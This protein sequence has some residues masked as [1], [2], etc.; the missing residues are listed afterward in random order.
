MLFLSHSCR[1]SKSTKSK[2]NSK[3]TSKK[4]NE[5][6]SKRS[7]TTTTTTTTTTHSP[8]SSG[9]TNN[10][11]KEC[12]LIHLLSQIDT[13][14]QSKSKAVAA[15]QSI[16]QA[17]IIQTVHY[18][19]LWKEGQNATFSTTATSAMSGGS[20]KSDDSNMDLASSSTTTTTTT[21]TSSNN[22]L[23]SFFSNHH[24][25]ATTTKSSSTSTSASTKNKKDNILEA[26][27]NTDAQM[28]ANLIIITTHILNRI[29]IQIQH[30][31][32]LKSA[33]STTTT[34]TTK[35]SKSSSVPQDQEK[36]HT[37]QIKE[38]E[39]RS[40]AVVLS[41]YAS[42][43]IQILL[44]DKS[45]L[46]RAIN[47]ASSSSS[48][49]S[50]RSSSGAGG[51]LGGSSN[52]SAGI[53][54][55]EEGLNARSVLSRAILTSMMA[56]LKS[57]SILSTINLSSTSTT[58]SSSSSENGIYAKLMW[59]NANSLETILAIGSNYRLV[60]GGN[61]KGSKSLSLSLG[62]S[63][64][65]STAT[66]MANN[67]STL[68]SSSMLS[69][70]GAIGTTTATAGGA[71]TGRVGGNNEL[72]SNL[73][74]D[75]MTTVS[76]HNVNMDV[77]RANEW[78]DICSAMDSEDAC[79]SI[80]G[81]EKGSSG[82]STSLSLMQNSELIDAFKATN[83]NL[84]DSSSSVLNMDIGEDEAIL[85]LINFNNNATRKSDGKKED[86]A[87][88]SS[89]ATKPPT[90]KRRI[91]SPTSTSSTAT[92]TRS[93]TLSDK[94]KNVSNEYTILSANVS[95]VIFS[96]KCNRAAFGGNRFNMK[97]WSSSAFAWTCNGQEIAL[98]T[99][100]NMFMANYMQDGMTNW[101]D[102][103][104]VVTVV[105]SS[106]TSTSRKKAAK[107]D[108]KRASTSGTS[109]KIKDSIIHIPGNLVLITYASRII[110]IVNEGGKL[111]VSSLQRNGGVEYVKLFEQ[112]AIQPASR[113]KSTTSTNKSRRQ[114]TRRS[115]EIANYAAG[116]VDG[117]Q[118]DEVMSSGS[119]E[120]S[121]NGSNKSIQNKRSDIRNLSLVVMEL[122][123][124][125]H[126]KCMEANVADLARL[127]NL[128]ESFQITKMTPKFPLQ[129]GERLLQ[130]FLNED[131]DK[132]DG[133]IN[134]FP[135]ENKKNLSDK[136]RYFPLVH[137]TLNTLINCA[138]SVSMSNGNIDD[139]ASRLTGIGA[140][141]ALRYGTVLN[142]IPEKERKQQKK[143]RGQSDDI[144]T[145]VVV[146]A[147]LTSWAV[148]HLS[149][150]LTKIIAS[151]K[152]TIEAHENN[153]ESQESSDEIMD[154][155][156]IKEPLSLIQEKDA[157]SRKY[158][159]LGLFRDCPEKQVTRGKHM[160]HDIHSQALALFM[161]ATN[162]IGVI[163]DESAVY[164]LIHYLLRIVTCCYSL[165]PRSNIEYYSKRS[166][167]P[168]SCFS[169]YSFKLLNSMKYHLS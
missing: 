91:E 68:H 6:S 142:R 5:S 122:L 11:I 157:D 163:S 92:R 77:R 74:H 120:K 13:L 94:K 104:K 97:K 59:I 126:Q 39:E 143:G 154:E 76:V 106:S 69:T 99:L 155:F 168:E 130:V 54:H 165:N 140:A 116:A 23:A 117:V 127:G 136:C 1:K 161:R 21:T 15:I 109:S 58:K 169:F 73:M 107:S 48:T 46:E 164:N 3:S 42:K 146:D 137:K 26:F 103:M 71:V 72:H 9:K 153:K 156:L 148:S 31:S 133:N 36:Q 135:L 14:S 49:T 55:G 84:F 141:L 51:G 16:S 10:N 56:V 27:E 17:T 60:K 89:S 25:N 75:E 47:L 98:E 145:I 38:E 4:K 65:S 12:L 8:S 123:L 118:A 93:K 138:T 129:E 45:Q 57:M 108:R 125:A 128:E 147:K 144:N 95:D 85:K 152:E 30:L 132:V 29:L 162:D 111:G 43:L 134:S 52:A 44:A 115:K 2:S 100:R 150:T 37:I 87:P 159:Y 64:S 101:E 131:D 113:T 7:S 70:S 53:G 160:K 66:I 78:N 50:S 96:L 90:K 19:S 67:Q 110:D 82:K 166:V 119:K 102:W 33:S 81:S 41:I 149:A 112:I 61:T 88:S 40:Y 105:S 83:D 121:S 24:H 114:S 32:Q 63:N 167:V 79:Y 151:A 22:P 20:T 62:T 80:D 35:T 34:S 28:N 158:Q 18:N 139:C 124:I 86:D